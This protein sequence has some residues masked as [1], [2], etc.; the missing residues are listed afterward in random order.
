MNPTI[1]HE[2][3]KAHIAELRRI[4]EAATLATRHFRSD[5]ATRRIDQRRR[6]A[7]RSVI[8]NLYTRARHQPCPACGEL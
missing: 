3:A 1:T 6:P 5:S 7:S 8:S 4:A 2:L